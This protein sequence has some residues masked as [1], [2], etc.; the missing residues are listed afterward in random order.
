MNEQNASVALGLSRLSIDEK[1]NQFDTISGSMTGNP[2]FATP[3]PTLA[4]VAA[5]RDAMRAD[6]KAQSLA[7]QA[8]KEAT[9]KVRASEKAY[10]TGA[11]Q[12]AAYVENRAAG[13][14]AIIQSA[15]MP[16]KKESAGKAPMSQ[17]TDVAVTMGD[18]PGQ[19]DL[20]Y[21]AVKN[22]KAYIARYG[23]NG[24]D[25]LTEKEVFT[26]SKGELHGLVSG[27]E[28]WVQVCATGADGNGPWSQP[29]RCMVP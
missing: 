23:Q 5:L 10:D 3:N 9:T 14:G 21:H 11:T 25:S 6:E 12:L 19:V 13:D 17:V 29:V 28:V 26:R 1:S 7:F 22:A 16:V 8:Y 2:A 15:G 20:S 18:E 24:P 27:K 4:A